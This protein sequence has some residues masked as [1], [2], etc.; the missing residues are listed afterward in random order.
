MPHATMDFAAARALMVD[1]QVR[2]N[3]VTDPRIIAAM[4]ALPRERFVPA[5]QASLA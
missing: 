3:K 5:S 2:P 4:R 1:G